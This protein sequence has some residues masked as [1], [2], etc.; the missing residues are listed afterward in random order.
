MPI[1]VNM[2]T[3]YTISQNGRIFKQL[4][5]TFENAVAYADKF[6]E[7]HKGDWTAIF[8]ADRPRKQV[9]NRCDEAGVRE[10]IL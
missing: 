2:I 3:N 10:V 7:T 4:S 6:A 1:I 8:T 5:D 9:Y